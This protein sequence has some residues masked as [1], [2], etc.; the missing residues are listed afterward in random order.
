MKCISK[1]W[2]GKMVV[3]GTNQELKKKENYICKKYE[4]LEEK[5]DPPHY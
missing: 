2:T 4:K 1:G 5:Q 3:F